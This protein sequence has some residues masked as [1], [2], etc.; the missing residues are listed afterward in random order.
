MRA[1]GN[2]G[3]DSQDYFIVMDRLYD[4]LDKR[5]EKWSSRSKKLKLGGRLFDRKGKKKGE[6]YEEQIVA[7]YDLADAVKY[8]HKK[9]ILYRD[10]KPENVAFDVRND[11]KLFDFGLSKS[12][13][14]LDKNDDGTYNLTGLTGSVRYMAPEVANEKPCKS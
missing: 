12:L 8:L 2:S 1:I 5:I 3:F 4:T 9:D 14:N 13:A 10:L 6:L 11:I 7:A